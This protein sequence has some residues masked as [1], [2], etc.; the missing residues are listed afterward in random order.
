MR[1]LLTTDTVGGVW[2]YA[3]ELARGLAPHGVDV[4]LA[5]MGAPLSPA[6][7]AEAA[8]LSNVELAESTYKLEW[9]DDPWDDVRRAGDWLLELEQSYR[10]DL[11]HLN[12]Y[13]HGSLPWSAPV[14]VVAHSCVLSWWQAV[15]REP[16]PS[17]WDRYRQAVADGLHDADLVVAPSRAMLDAVGHHY[18]PLRRARAIY[19]ARDPGPYRRAT[20]TCRKERI[21]LAAGRLW[22][23]AK[24]IAALDAIAARL[25]WPVY[26]AGD[27]RHPNGAEAHLGRVRPLGKLPP[28]QL[29]QWLGRASIYALPARYEPF[30][31]SAL[32]AAFAGCALV[33]GD[34][35][36]LREVW[37]DAA[38]YIP[39]DD[40]EAL[41]VA[42]NDLIAD[43]RY[44]ADM[45]A[46]AGE[47]A[48]RY[49]PERMA[50][51]YVNAY[52]E[53]LDPSSSSSERCEVP[54]PA[55][56][57]SAT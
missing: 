32:E 54:Q 9:M 41:A 44:R 30:G 11:V 33:L 42:I 1:L 18:G 5:T 35:P 45:A 40:R 57:R 37:G 2:T 38:V 34:I 13:A 26:V 14:M 53:L 47:R 48:E 10:P 24:N 12:G 27:E 19:N 21:V 15:K 16:A 49:T 3:L 20:R 36:S 31:L 52:R 28:E 50:S 8:A 6:Q 46:R 39:P 25:R 22:D 51:E 23:E 29:A 56:A 55:L 4:L 7:R 43:P 17:T